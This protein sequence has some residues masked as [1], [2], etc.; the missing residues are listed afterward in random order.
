MKKSQTFSL[1]SV[2][3][4]ALCVTLMFGLA[5]CSADN[6]SFQE[7]SQ[8]QNCV[9]GG[10]EPDA[11][12][13]VITTGAGGTGG[14]SSSASTCFCNCPEGVPLP[15]GDNV[16]TDSFCALPEN[17]GAACCLWHG[18]TELVIGTCT[19][20]GGPVANCFYAPPS[21]SSGGTQ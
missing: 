4:Y 12:A 6:S 21:S 5:A 16:A 15:L 2:E 20:T 17:L 3:T 11:G 18:P 9:T 10:G 13:N 19:N 1:F 7:Q 14:T 8:D